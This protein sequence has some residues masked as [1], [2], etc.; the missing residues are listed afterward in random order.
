MD[1]TV[2]ASNA[3]RKFSELLR[4]VRAGQTYVVTAHGKPIAKLIPFE[5]REDP[6]TLA[7]AVLFKRLRAQPVTDIG[8]WSRDELY[9]DKG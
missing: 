5:P 4:A 6:R 3:N 7:K 2:S 1:K 9:E 8:P